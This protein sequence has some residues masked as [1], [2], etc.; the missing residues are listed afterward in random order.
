[1][2][3]DLLDPVLDERRA[4]RDQAPL[5]HQ[6]PPL[7]V[8][9]EPPV[10]LVQPGLEGGDVPAEQV[11][12]RLGEGGSRRRA[13]DVLD[14]ARERREAVV[15]EGRGAQ[16]REVGVQVTSPERTHRP[17]YRRPEDRVGPHE[18]PVLLD[19]LLV[20]EFLGLHG[21]Q[22]GRAGYEYER[23][24]RYR[25][26]QAG[27]VP[28]SIPP[29]EG[30]KGRVGVLSPRHRAQRRELVCEQARASGAALAEGTALFED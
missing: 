24:H 5:E 26:A 27:G 14:E 28:P 29:P 25:L 12:L 2:P 16:R 11:Q 23:E 18:P 17:E 20:V 21:P 15:L 1:M 10:A 9:E 22:P 19:A 6:P 13:I 8:A 7:R 3:A 4:A 30:V